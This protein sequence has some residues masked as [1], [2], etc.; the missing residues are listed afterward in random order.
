[1]SDRLSRLLALVPWLRTHPGASIAAAAAAFGT[2]SQEISA[3]VDL[4]FCCGLPGGGPG[5]L[6]DFAFQG[7]T[8]TVLDPQ[9]LDRPLRLDADEA[10]ALLVAVRALA[11]VPGLTERDALERVAAK[12]EAAVGGVQPVVVALT[13]ADPAVLATL[14]AGLET[15]RRLHLTYLGAHRDAVTERDVDPLRLANRTGHWYLDGWCHL[16]EATRV[17]RV[18]RIEAAVLLDVAA[19]PPPDAV[20]RDLADGLFVPAPDDALIELEL[21]AGALWVA[22]HYPCESI[23]PLPAGGARVALRTPDTAW[24]VG[25]ALRLGGLG[26]VLSP[27]ELVAAVRAEAERALAAYAGQPDP[28]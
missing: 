27:P 22:D 19:A 3:D 26:R 17:F 2:S 6:I 25:L 9:L 14:R 20:P 21:S 16:A 23:T 5:D 28:D 1:V 11:D 15:G 12:L 10:M 18:D 7:D 13:E 8:V 24:I 4:L